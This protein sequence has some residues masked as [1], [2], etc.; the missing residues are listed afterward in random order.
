MYVT[1]G[2]Q[3][4]YCFTSWHLISSW[5]NTAMIW[6]IR[7]QVDMIGSIRSYELEDLTIGSL[8][9]LIVL[10]HELDGGPQHS[11][12][13][14]KFRLWFFDNCFRHLLQCYNLTSCHNNV[15][16]PRTSFYVFV[17]KKRK[18]QQNSEPRP[19]HCDDGKFKIKHGSFITF[20]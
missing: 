14:S 12:S 6:S 4:L 11:D 1:L 3:F 8:T 15:L 9:P 17:S 5:T 20:R 18:F 2:E 13:V 16:N 19:T 10:R 7:Y